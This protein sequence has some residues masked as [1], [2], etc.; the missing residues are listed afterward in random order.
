MEKFGNEGFSLVFISTDVYCVIDYA[1]VAVF[2]GGGD[3]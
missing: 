1:G 2:V 3:G